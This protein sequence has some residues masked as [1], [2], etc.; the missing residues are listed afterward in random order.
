MSIRMLYIR[1]FI[2]SSG[3]AAHCYLQLSLVQVPSSL[4][5]VCL[6]HFMKLPKISEANINFVESNVSVPPTTLNDLR[7]LDAVDESLL[8]TAGL[9]KLGS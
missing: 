1:S 6:F 3:Y 8:F 7:E 5:L 2:L 4:P 9:P